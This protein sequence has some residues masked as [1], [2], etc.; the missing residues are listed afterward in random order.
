MLSHTSGNS[1]PPSGNSYMYTLRPVI[2]TL[3]PV[4]A[5]LRP[6]I[7][8]LLYPMG[9]VVGGYYIIYWF[10]GF[11]HKIVKFSLLVQVHCTTV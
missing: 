9:R 10:R 6:V 2:A 4:I 8:P 5:T 3:R 1:Y 7:P 11:I